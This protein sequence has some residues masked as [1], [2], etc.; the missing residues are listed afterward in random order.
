VEVTVDEPAVRFEQEAPRVA[1]PPRRAEILIGLLPVVC[2]WTFLGILI[3][4]RPD[5]GIGMLRLLP[6]QVLPA[7]PESALGVL[8]YSG[9]PWLALYTFLV[10]ADLA[11]SLPLL[12]LTG[13]LQRR[14]RLG[15]FLGRLEAR[16]LRFYERHPWLRRLGPLGLAVFV[17]FPISGTGSTVGVLVGR[18]LA[19]PTLAIAPAVVL[20]TLVRWAAVVGGVF[21]VSR[22][23]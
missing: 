9:T 8:V 18:V 3:G 19:F 13:Y 5:I 10:L 21:A 22:L 20:G 23:I 12:A 6:L 1:D 4:L 15:R 14:P 11:T 16:G 17:S 2:L 7:G